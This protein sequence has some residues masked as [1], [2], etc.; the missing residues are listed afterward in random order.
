M[1]LRGDKI[2]L[3]PITIDDTDDIVRW[4]N[5]DFVRQNFIFREQFTKELHLEWLKSRVETGQVIQ[6]IIYTCAE[7][8]KIGSVYLRDVDKQRGEAEYGI[9][10]GQR[11]AL[12]HGYGSEACRMMVEYAREELG[13]S[14]LTLRLLKS[15]EPA[16]RSYE[17]AGFRLIE[18]KTELRNNEKIVFMEITLD[19]N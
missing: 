4:R 9:F 15:N 13:L 7:N 5:E 14:R 19:E 1:K 3:K 11:E 12:L 16:R 2:Y 8:Q 17:K 18:G 6:F 10:I